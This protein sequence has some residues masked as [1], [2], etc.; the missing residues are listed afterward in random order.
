MNLSIES[1]VYL[2]FVSV[3]LY[4]N[5]LFPYF[6]IQSTR[7]PFLICHWSYKERET[8]KPRQLVQITRKFPT[9][10]NA[11]TVVNKGAKMTLSI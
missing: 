8:N 1:L 2:L 6:R 7:P 3:S 9:L 5:L 11:F 10:E 4:F